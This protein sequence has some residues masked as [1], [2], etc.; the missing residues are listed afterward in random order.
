MSG[1]SGCGKSSAPQLGGG[2]EQHRPYSGCLTVPA[3]GVQGCPRGREAPSLLGT[4]GK[5]SSESSELPSGLCLPS[6]SHCSSRGCASR[7]VLPW[8]LHPEQGFPSQAPQL[9]RYTVITGLK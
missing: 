8:G 7:A 3:L 2:T 5:H 1:S 6:D 9:N 4:A